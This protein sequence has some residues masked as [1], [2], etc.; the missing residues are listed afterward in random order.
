M[1]RKNQILNVQGFDMTDVEITS[2]NLFLLP[3]IRTELQSVYKKLEEKC[4]E[5]NINSLDNELK[6]LQE[7]VQKIDKLYLKVT[8]EIE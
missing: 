6:A 1:V 4:A 2:K 3:K 7:A 8:F 5:L